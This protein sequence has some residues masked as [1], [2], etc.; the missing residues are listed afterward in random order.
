MTDEQRLVLIWSLSPE[1][2]ATDEE[3]EAW[4]VLCSKHGSAN[5]LRK[6]PLEITDTNLTRQIKFYKFVV[7]DLL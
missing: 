3:Y 7:E 2:M 6:Y 4:I 5:Y 1:R